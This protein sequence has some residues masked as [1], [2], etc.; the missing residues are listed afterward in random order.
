MSRKE[1]ETEVI[2]SLVMVVMK[3]SRTVILAGMSPKSHIHS[4]H[5]QK[6]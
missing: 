3:N 1:N 6:F 5:K 4:K 2:L